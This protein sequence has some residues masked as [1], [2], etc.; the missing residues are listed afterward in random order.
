MSSNQRHQTAGTLNAH[1]QKIGGQFGYAQRQ[2]DLSISLGGATATPNFNKP[3]PQ[4]AART[5]QKQAQPAQPRMKAVLAAKYAAAAAMAAG[6][7]AATTA[8]TAMAA[9][10]SPVMGVA[11][12]L[13]GGLATAFSVKTADSAMTAPSIVR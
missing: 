3:A 11:V 2:A 6:G 13:A 4:A 1:G 9:S 8:G 7:F 12:L 5:A 10:A